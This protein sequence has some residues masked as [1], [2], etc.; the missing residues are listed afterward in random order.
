MFECVVNISEGRDVAVLEQLSRAAGNSMRDRHRDRHHHRSVFT[1]INEPEELLYDLHTLA[2]TAFQRI[3]L[4]RHTGVHPRFGVVDVVPFVALD[5]ARAGEACALRDETAEW[6]AE[7]A[8]IPVFLYGPLADGTTR[9]LPEVRRDAFESLA[10]DF[11]PDF[12]S[13]NL[14][15]VAVGCRPILVAW[16]LWLHNVTLDQATEMAKAVR[17]PAVRALAFEVGDDVQVSC[18]FIDVPTGRPSIVYD[19][20]KS[21]LSGSGE[22][23]RAELVGLIPTALLDAEDENR[24]EELGLGRDATIEARLAL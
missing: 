21:M 5:P 7:N 14:G 4:S 13:R 6:F 9:T 23:E 2:R 24:W 19:Q 18:N 17:A 1:L 22:I 15:A 20:V 8:S 11:G 3:D 10:P 12:P 16:N